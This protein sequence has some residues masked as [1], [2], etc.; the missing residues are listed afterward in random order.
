[1][2]KTIKIENTTFNLAATGAVLCLYKQQFGVEYYDDFLRITAINTNISATDIE[3]AAISLEIG[4]RLIWSMAKA[5]D[6][7]ISDPDVWI[8]EFEDFPL[9]ELMPIAMELLG[10]S[11]E[12]VIANG[13][14]GGEKLTSENLIACC[15][16]CGLNM[17]DVNTLSIGFLLNSINEYIRIKSGG[18]SKTGTKRKAT[19]ADFDRF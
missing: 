15:L 18:K 14:A 10:K 17:N 8:D 2:Q 12:Q 9:T 5:A 16:S 11:F 1:M 13:T 4:Y 6:P 3:K 19:Q 7:S